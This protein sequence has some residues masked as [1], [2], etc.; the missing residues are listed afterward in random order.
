MHCFKCLFQNFKHLS[1]GILQGKFFFKRDSYKFS[2]NVVE[3]NNIIFNFRVSIHDF[4][5]YFTFTSQCSWSIKL[6]DS[7]KCYILSMKNV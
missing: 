3:H 2:Q 4:A 1:K 7:L 6:Q 5:L